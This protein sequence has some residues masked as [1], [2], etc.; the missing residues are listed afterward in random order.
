MDFLLSGGFTVLLLVGFTQR[1]LNTDS[2]SNMLNVCAM[3]VI[4]RFSL[5]VTALLMPVHICCLLQMLPG[6]AE[7]K[8]VITKQLR[9]SYHFV[10]MFV[11]CMIYSHSMSIN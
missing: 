9:P 1:P 8:T 11:R 6:H 5:L 7:N 3:A 10:F 4:A 2:T